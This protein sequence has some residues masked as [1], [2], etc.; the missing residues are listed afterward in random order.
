M[1]IHSD[2]RNLIWLLEQQHKGM[3]GRW[4]LALDTDIS[5]VSGSSQ[6]VAHPLSESSVQG[7]ARRDLG[8]INRRKILMG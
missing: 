2:H 7:G 6:L 1:V 8:P 5:Y 3:I 4:Y